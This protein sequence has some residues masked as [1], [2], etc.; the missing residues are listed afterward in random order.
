MTDAAAWQAPYGAERVR[1]RKI[2]RVAW[3][4]TPD[5]FGRRLSHG[6]MSAPR[7]IRLMG[8]LLYLADIGYIR[9]L[10][11]AMPPGH[12][13]S[14]VAS[15]WNPAWTLERKPRS[16]IILA[17]YAASLAVEKG[18]AVRE[19]LTSNDELL[20]VRLKADSRAADRWQT[21]AGGGM[22][23]AGIGGGITGRRAHKF[24]IDDPFKGFDD[25]HSEA[26]R[27]NVWNW[28]R[29]VV[30]TR[31]FPGASVYVVQTRWNED[32]LIGKVS[33]LPGWVH[34]RLPA[35]AE[36]TETLADVVGSELVARCAR[37]GIW[38][39]D[40][41]REPGEP[42]WPW[43]IEPC[44]DYPDGVPW[45]DA[46]EMEAVRVEVGEY[47]WWTLYQQKP[48]PVDGDMFPRSNWQYVDRL[49]G[50]PSRY[51][52]VRRWDMAG[53]EKGGDW[54]AGCLMARDRRGGVYIVDVRRR[55]LG[56]KGVEDFIA[57]TAAEDRIR[58]GPKLLTRIEQE[59]GSAGVSV[60][61]RFVSDVLP[62][63]NVEFKGSTGD[64]RVRALG[65][66]AQQGARNVF[67]VRQDDGSGNPVT[68]SWFG[69][70]V[71]ECAAFPNGV[72]DD[73]VD[74]A[75][76]AFN[77]LVSIMKRRTKAAA[78]SAANRHVPD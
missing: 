74:A 19:L 38:L 44:D 42:L 24:A 23:T 57:D 2:A 12:A 68:P 61:D 5:T 78:R 21:T 70:F 60:R 55:R 69:E 10:T 15:E 28:Y 8:W 76:S 33:G 53:T 39:P 13:K 17:S 3:K 41:H 37:D 59:P 72:N 47:I 50:N 75:S 48:Q 36:G 49:P 7:H 43:L 6:A 52:M 65:L 32:D 4:A 63:Y 26:A 31:L 22:W 11:I 54:T 25:S 27:E 71:D 35:V 51:Q 20:T 64:K 77:D 1:Q 46:E 58:Y 67:L 73:Q 62:G 29:S 30:R 56:P 16:R 34:C 66:S 9:R 45:F 18:K 14:T 40:W